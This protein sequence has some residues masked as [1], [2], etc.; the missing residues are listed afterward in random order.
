MLVVLFCWRPWLVM[1]SRQ[2]AETH[3]AAQRYRQAASWL[4][5]AESLDERHAH[6]QFLLARLHRKLGQSER[7]QDHLLRARQLGYDAERCRR[8]QWLAE[9]QAGQLNDAARHYALLLDDPQGD[10]G[11]ICEAYA[12]GHMLHGNFTQAM[13]I[14]E[15]WHAADPAAAQPHHMR[16]LIW[17]HLGDYQAAEAAWKQALRLSP[18]HSAAALAL[19]E[20]LTKRK[21][22]P[23]ALPLFELALADEMHWLA[24]AI[25]KA[26]CLRL[27][28]DG[29]AA[30]VLLR[31]VLLR[32][33]ENV[34][35]RVQLGQLELAG[36]DA[37]RAEQLLAEAYRRQ[38][39]D[40]DVRYQL[41]TA[42]SA[43]GKT[44]QAA[45]HF[46][47]A[48][49]ARRALEQAREEIIRLNDDPDDADAR[50]EVGRTLLKYGR[51]Q[52]ALI[53]LR[54]AL[55][56]DTGHA[57]AH[58]ALAEYYEQMAEV[59]PDALRLA[60]YHR[61]Q[62]TRSAPRSSPAALPESSP[63]ASPVQEPADAC[64]SA[65]VSP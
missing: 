58:Q 22:L 59:A 27:Q 21:R 47:Y 55:N 15:G 65:P 63:A 44:E 2:Q 5:R 11:E 16:G 20:M 32:D 60:R 49:E 53:W 3:L 18:D 48:D 35:A 38:P 54:S 45:E 24:A 6:T 13:R 40:A 51:F 19:A 42:L 36:G 10:A 64:S 30:R 1:V 46:A 29:D 26:E 62:A 61:Q 12:N 56:V 25:G 37:S 28:G 8:E 57:E 31:E 4:E 50:A 9:A 52:E 43:A 17:N 33:P 23:E 7:F 41:A 14:L 34:P 39:R